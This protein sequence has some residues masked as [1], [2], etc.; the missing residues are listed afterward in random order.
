MKSLKFSKFQLTNIIIGFI[1]AIILILSIKG[2][3]GNPSILDLK[4]PFWVNNGPLELSPDRG[5]FALLYSIVENNSFQFT[6]DIAS[7]AAPDVG[8]DNGKFVSLFAPG[9]SLIIIPG[10]ILGYI[11]G[12]SVVG[13]IAI[14]T[15]FSIIN[16]ILI[17]KICLRLDTG[18][19]SANIAALTFLFATNAFSYGVSLYQHHVTVSLILFSIY[20][21]MAFRPVIALSVV[22]VLC[23]VGIMVD[24]PNFFLMFPIGVYA[25]TKILVVNKVGENFTFKLNTFYLATVLIAI[26]PLFLFAKINQ[27]S[28][29]SPTKLAGTVSQVKNF[30]TEISDEHKPVDSLDTKLIINEQTE[31]DRNAVGFFETRDMLR[32][33]SILLISP[34]RGV[35]FYTPVI[36]LGLL[37]FAFLYRRDTGLGNL[38]LSIILINLVLYSM[39][40]DPWG[41][42]AF[43]PRYLIPSFAILS[44]LLGLAFKNYRRNIFFVLAFTA[45]FTYSLY[46]NTAGALSSNAVPPQVEVLKLEELSGQIQRY[47]FKRN[48]DLLNVNASKSFVFNTFVKDSLNSWQYFWIIFTTV[49]TVTIWCVFSAFFGSKNEKN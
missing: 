12:A 18:V 9:L 13:T 1:V 46:V 23:I 25:L 38:F 43:G 3:V 41:G 45:L 49:F 40:G 35:V 7:Y 14:I 26:I 36:L 19:F 2:Q 15:A 16:F 42:W 17:R 34:D 8:Y 44:I 32:G 48:T 39:W 20:A 31:S 4:T 24:Y 11:L 22:W 29:G 21:L 37:G 5:R 28:Y 30:E 10:Y 47:T 6:N 33:F 27:E